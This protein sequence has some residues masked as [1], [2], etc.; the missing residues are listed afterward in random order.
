MKKLLPGFL[1]LTL[2][3]PTSWA[4]QPGVPQSLHS[5]HVFTPGE[6]PTYLLLLY[7]NDG[8]IIGV[9]SIPS[10]QC[11]T[12][13]TPSVIIQ[14]FGSNTLTTAVLQYNIDGST[15]QFIEWQ[16]VLAPFFS[17]TI[18]LP[19]L[20]VAP[21]THTLNVQVTEANGETDENELNDYSVQF[22]IVGTSEEAPYLE[23]FAAPFLPDGYFVENKNS[24]P[25]W[26]IT[27]INNQQNISKC[28][29]MPFYYNDADND[30]DFLYL[31]NLNLTNLSS[32]FLGFDVAYAY[33]SD[34]Y[35]DELRI[36]ASI[37]CGGSWEML[38]D[39][40]KDE[41]ATAPFTDLP[42]MPEASQ[43]RREW[44]DL[45]PYAG[46]DNVLIRFDAISGHGNNLYI[47]NISVDENVGIDEAGDAIPAILVYPNP[48]NELVHVNMT[49]PSL[50]ESLS[51]INY[52][53]QLIMSIPAA[54][55]QSFSVPLGG[56][57]GGA[58]LLEL[59]NRDQIVSAKKL[60][61]V[62]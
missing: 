28:I 51:L 62:H 47:D 30:E 54:G 48:A 45:S 33:Y 14:N 11:N 6:S 50:N 24:G 8:G 32:V 19:E 10:F 37:N 55:K 18:L 7:D 40:A 27:E 41:L 43:W 9:N 23:N 44:V 56:V 3:S 39:K 60:L 53:G 15:P 59:R 13:L 5:T 46:F 21:G 12:S 16:G 29:M 36:D 34:F 49:E 22:N 17:D 58:Y 20:N 35:F 26:M 25:S 52:V 1:L 31:K 42:W 38:Y 4:Q 57:P 61:I 2:I